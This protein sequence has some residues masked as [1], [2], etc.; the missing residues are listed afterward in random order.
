[1]LATLFEL[2]TF[3]YGKL[4]AFLRFANHTKMSWQLSDNFLA[5]QPTLCGQIYD[6]GTSRRPPGGAPERP[7]NPPRDTQEAHW[8]DPGAPSSVSTCAQR[9]MGTHL[10][11]TGVTRRHP[12]GTPEWPR[13]PPRHTPEAHRRVPWITL[14]S[15]FCTLLTSRWQLLASSWQIAGN[16]WPQ[17]CNFLAARW[18]LLGAG[19]QVLADRCQLSAPALA[20]N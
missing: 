1:M 13:S 6:L 9:H 17:A 2:A 7:W 20:T 3:S 14:G 5:V 11:D 18:Q 15:D 4:P 16:F 10:G 12:V 19:L 8:N